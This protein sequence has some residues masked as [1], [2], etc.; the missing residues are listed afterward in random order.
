MIYFVF[1]QGLAVFAAS[2]FYGPNEIYKKE[3]ELIQFV[4][5]T[6]ILAIG[7]TTKNTMNTIKLL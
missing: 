3:F 1:I 5:L 7:L 6:N 2:E 4:R